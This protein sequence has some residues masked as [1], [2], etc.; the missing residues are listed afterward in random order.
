MLYHTMFEKFGKEF[1][2]L[3]FCFIYVDGVV[4]F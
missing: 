1:V 4:V 3:C 2:G